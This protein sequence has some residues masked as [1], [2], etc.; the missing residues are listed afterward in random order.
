[1]RQKIK[2]TSRQLDMLVEAATI[3]NRV[4]KRIVD[5]L[6]AYYEPMV[7]IY[8]GQD[9]YHNG[10]LIMNK[11]DGE[12]MAPFALFDHLKAKFGQNLSDKF[13]QQVI[14]DWYGGELDDSYMLS[15]AVTIN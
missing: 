12:T 1:M 8:A 7:G 4:V 9:E 5:Y 15:K 10:G 11:V 6:N 14:R 3:Q 2:I 13:I